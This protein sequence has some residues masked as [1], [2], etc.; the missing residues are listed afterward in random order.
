V[1]ALLLTVALL[2]A[3]DE[4]V[5]S[6]GLS[7]PAGFNVSVFSDSAVANDIHC[8]T[9]D[10][11]GRV[12]VSGR[13]YLRI[14]VEGKD[15]KAGK[16]LE[17]K[18]PVKE[19]AHGLFWEDGHLWCVGDGGLRIYRDVDK[20][21]IDR[22][23]ELLF[24]CKTGG[25]HTAHAVNRG[26]DGWLYLLVGDHAGIDHKTA[27]S[28]TSPIT[29][30]TG[31]C[32]L[33]FSPDFKRIEIVAEGYR[34][35][36]AMDW[37]P[38]G[39]LF[40][41]DSDNERCVSLP[42]YEPTRLY[43]VQVGGHHG[44]LGPRHAATWR[45]PPYF[46]DT[47]APVATLGRGSPTGVLCYK[48]VQFPERYRGGL[49]L[50]DWTFGVVHFVDL[51]KQGSSYAGKPETF[52]RSVGEDG[53]APT[54]AAVHPLTGDLFVSIGGRGTRGAVYRIRYGKDV[55]A[56][57]PEDVAK[58]QPKARS[59]EWKDGLDR[60][61]IREATGDDL[62]A[63][64]RALEMIWRHRSRLKLEQLSEAIAP[65]GTHQDPALRRSAAG[66][67][68][69]LSEKDRVEVSKGIRTIFGT[70]TRG[71]AA[72]DWNV[73]NSLLIGVRKKIR[74]DLCLD[75]VR[76]LQL[77][78]GDVGA[79]GLLA[80]GRQRAVDA[81]PLEAATAPGVPVRSRGR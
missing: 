60:T 4:R 36:Y 71:L 40:T 78:L 28:P 39:E 10:P 23:S 20:G 72:P 61:L 52:A 76:V 59:L 38:D 15:G 80:P 81:G 12:T 24:K 62:H 34:N 65:N 55:P 70:T 26:P 27:T 58:L 22:P 2:P 31:G 64:R 32:V 30:P 63:R 13:G 51:K 74:L 50:L 8:M 19:G 18:H 7:V 1:T 47:V 44:W 16:T 33:R 46:L 42:W 49:F 56:F 48:H 35:P 68:R 67:L 73:T 69:S 11:Q 53:F 75:C 29:D 9:I 37:N 45:R 54:A 57:K 77:K 17:F 41:F 5:V 3:A 66:L 14:L 6:S 79:G 21:G 25:E 43:H